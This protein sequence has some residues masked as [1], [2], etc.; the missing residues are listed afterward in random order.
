MGVLFNSKYRSHPPKSLYGKY[1]IK[2]DKDD[3]PGPG[4][5]ILPSDFGIY[6]SKNSGEDVP[7]EKVRKYENYIPIIREE[8]LRREEEARIRKE[9]KMNEYTEKTEEDVDAGKMDENNKKEEE[10]EIKPNKVD[11]PQI[12]EA[13]VRLNNNNNNN[14]EEQQQNDIEEAQVIKPKEE[15]EP[16]IEEAKV[17]LNNNGDNQGQQSFIAEGHEVQPEDLLNES[18]N[19]DDILN[20]NNQPEPQEQQ[21]EPN[22]IEKTNQRNNGFLFSDINFIP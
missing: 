1:R 6:R 5:Y 10:E 15:D 20:Q 19:D 13:Q 12:E 3:N 8:R 17:S 16:Q 21:N 22:I 11:E 4:E 18:Y 2:D 14:Q 7:K 9:A